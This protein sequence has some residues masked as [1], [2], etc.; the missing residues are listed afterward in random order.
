LDFVLQFKIQNYFKIQN[1]FLKYI[2][3]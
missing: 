2:Y 1:K 3:M